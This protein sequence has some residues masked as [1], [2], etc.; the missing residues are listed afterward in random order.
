MPSFPALMRRISVAVP[1][2]GAFA[3]VAFLDIPALTV[4]FFSTIALLCG[5]EAAAL[6]DGKAPLPLKVAAAVLTA[7]GSTA[8]AVLPPGVALPIVLVP[9]ALAGLWWMAAGGMEDASGRLTGSVGLL[10]TVAMAFGLLAKLR[11]E[12]DSPWILLVPLLVCW[13]GDSAA[14]FA[15]V[16]FGRHKLAP[17]VS[18][19]KSWEGFTAGM[20]A[21]MGG[22]VLAGT[23]G[24]GFPAGWM[25]LA[26]AAGGAAGVLGD[27]FESALK[28]NAG[29]KDSGCLLPGHG[30]FLDRFDSLLGA[31]PA[32]WLILAVML[33]RG[34]AV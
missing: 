29:V 30:G 32:V 18:P 26:G 8:V 31:S 13:A 24:A 21:S 2:I 15:G 3:A 22:A 20:V 28:R 33:S 19:A 27:L 17:R 12:F 25:L 1:G 9:G 23:C 34:V 5:F 14:Y 6:L 7:G 11:L 4:A 10:G 16:A